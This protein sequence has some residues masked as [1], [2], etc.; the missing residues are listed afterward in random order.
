MNKR[1][2]KS[3]K[4]ILM[5]ASLSSMIAGCATVSQRTNTAEKTPPSGILSAEQI[6]LDELNTHFSK[7]RNIGEDTLE[8]YK[9]DMLFTCCCAQKNNKEF[10]EFDGTVYRADDTAVE[11]FNELIKARKKSKKTYIF[12]GEEKEACSYYPADSQI[13]IFG[14]LWEELCSPQSEE[15]KKM[16]RTLIDDYTFP[17]FRNN[18]LNRVYEICRLSGYPEVKCETT[19]Q[20]LMGK[21]I[22]ISSNKKRSHY[23]PSNIG[24]GTIYLVPKFPQ[25]NGPVYDTDELFAELAHAFRDNN[26]IFGETSQFLGDAFK[27][28]VT[29]NS[30]GFGPEAQEKNYKNKNRMEYDTHK[31]VEPMLVQYAKGLIQTIPELYAEIEKQREKNGNTYSLKSS[32]SKKVRQGQKKKDGILVSVFGYIRTIKTKQ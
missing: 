21:I 2:K 4:K 30:I 28:I 9:A 1:L 27:D 25:G 12:N 5:T 7:E 32:A 29:L 6:P 22:E 11:Q 15:T 13:K 16:I 17:A 23:E 10:F 26:N 31:V 19:E 14:N 3:I 20:S 18:M 8:N 24:R